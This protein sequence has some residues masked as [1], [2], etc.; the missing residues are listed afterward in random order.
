MLRK[1]LALKGAAT[2]LHQVK[3]RPLTQA[4]NEAEV[5]IHRAQ[6]KLDSKQ[7]RHSFSDE[8]HPVKQS[9]RFTFFRQ[10]FKHGDMVYGFQEPRT[11]YLREALGAE[12]MALG[13]VPTADMA[14]RWIVPVTKA[15]AE[16]EMPKD[17]EHYHRFL[18][19]HLIGKFRKL[20][21]RNVEKTPEE[22]KK[23]I[24]RSCL[25]KIEETAT[26]GSR[27]HFL[28]DDGSAPWNME[29]VVKRQAN[30]TRLATVKELRFIYKNHE[31]LAGHIQFWK[32]AQKT[33]APWESDPTLWAQFQTKSSQAAAF[34]AAVNPHANM[35]F[36]P[37]AVSVA[38]PVTANLSVAS[39]DISFQ[40]VVPVATHS[41]AKKEESCQCVLL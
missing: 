9:P 32:D 12:A 11:E 3:G 8:E 15:D 1:Q 22:R 37:V 39:A 17:V 23:S 7:R 30:I 20:A 31:R 38:A 28:L 19:K 33:V 13:G 25:A 36:Q 41:S 10:D 18:Q 26:R 16:A 21:E 40:P 29:A 5:S 14:N 2:R 34:A 6:S 35:L 4:E 24:V 27:V